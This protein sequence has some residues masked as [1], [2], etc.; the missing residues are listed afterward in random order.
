MAWE[1]IKELWNPCRRPC[2]VLR[3][4]LSI[5]DQLGI[6]NIISDIGNAYH[7]MGDYHSARKQFQE[8]V[9]LYNKLLDKHENTATSYHNLAITDLALGSYPEALEC[10]RQA[11]TM[12]L[13]VFGQHKHTANSFHMLGEVHEKINDFTSAVEAFQT[14]SDMRSTLLGDHQ[15]TTENY[16]KLGLAK[17]GMGDHKGALESLQKALQLGRKLSTGNQPSIADITNNIGHMYHK[18]GD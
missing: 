11:S 16:H 12:R 17:C 7:K 13:E 15:D 8:A 6:A 10:F 14:A 1:I 18:I 3:R 5:G 2:N 4:K 9:D